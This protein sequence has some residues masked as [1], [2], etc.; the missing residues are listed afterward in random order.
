[1]DSK[2]MDVLGIACSNSGRLP[3]HLALIAI[4]S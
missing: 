4:S 1:M 2:I 3:T